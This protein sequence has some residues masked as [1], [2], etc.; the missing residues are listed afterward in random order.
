MHKEKIR[1]GDIFYANLNPVA[2]SEQGDR[3]PVL[4]VQ[5]NTGNDHSSTVIVVPFTRNLRKNP[6]PTHVVIP[7]SCGLEGD[8]LALT[9][10]I[11]TIDRR[12]LSDYIGRIEDGDLLREIDKALAIGIGLG[13]AGT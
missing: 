11:R 7:H 6:L 8:S 4:I 2:G 3:R 9:E 10:Q 12:R 1:R 5:N 13:R